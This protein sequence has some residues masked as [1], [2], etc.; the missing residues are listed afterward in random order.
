MTD[1]T[2][3]DPVHYERIVVPLDRSERAERALGH[4][5]TLAKALGVPV[6]LLHVVDVT[7]LVQAMLIAP[8]L[9]DITVL[10]AMSMVE[11]EEEL[12][13]QYLE[14]IGSQL[15]QDGVSVAFE[16]RRDLEVDGVIAA[17][18]PSD[19]LVMATHGKGGIA[20]WFLGDEADAVIRRSPAPVL[21]VRTAPVPAE[22]SEKS[23]VAA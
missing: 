19:L 13:R 20:R 22:A 9:D 14:G 8:T 15:G 16:I 10:T 12:A 7:P 18:R 23:E 1:T 3:G 21:L 6:Y 4:A 5:R 2:H 17:V 11:T